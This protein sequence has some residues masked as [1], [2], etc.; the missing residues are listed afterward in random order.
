MSVPT[1]P[2]E[3][4]EVMVRKET[5]H[6]LNQPETISR[7]FGLNLSEKPKVKRKLSENNRQSGYFVAYDRKQKIFVKWSTHQNQLAAE[8]QKLVL[9]NTLVR[10]SVVR[11]PN[12]R[13]LKSRDGCTIAAF[14]YI[15]PQHD[16]SLTT[17]KLVRNLCQTLTEF[18]N[19]PTR[20]LE[21][22]YPLKTFDDYLLQVRGLLSNLRNLGFGTQSRENKYR[23]FFASIKTLPPSFVHADFAPHN[24]VPHSQGPLILFDFEKS[25]IGNPLEDLARLLNFYMI[26][27]PTAYN[28]LEKN[29]LSQD[30][31]SLQRFRLL[32]ALFLANHY[33]EKCQRT[34]EPMP[35]IQARFWLNVSE[36]LLR[37]DPP[38]SESSRDTILRQEQQYLPPK[39]LRHQQDYLVGCR[40]RRRRDL[41]NPTGQRSSRR[42]STA[43]KP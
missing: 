28:Q 3:G 32:K 10:T 27:H 36:R 17:H 38:I 8:I 34:P 35:S 19:I 43:A 21:P 9:F 7:L 12:Y 29:N 20:K 22:L 41:K 13:Y 24:F 16:R 40:R 14:E 15:E 11:A 25:V 30:K 1:S 6:Q 18:R 31:E 39:E 23:R 42:S 37:G 2:A 5:G 33:A 26:H 4:Y